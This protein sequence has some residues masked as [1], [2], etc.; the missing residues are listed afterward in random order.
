MTQT[1]SQLALDQELIA[2][3]DVASG[4]T[5]WEAEFVDSTLRQ[6]CSERRP[7]SA[8]Q[9]ATAEKIQRALDERGTRS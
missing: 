5:Q 2:S 4:L 7:L 9:R 6:V 1:H 8:K 3:I